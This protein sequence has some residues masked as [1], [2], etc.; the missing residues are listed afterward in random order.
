MNGPALKVILMSAT[1]DSERLSSYFSD[2][3]ILIAK[4]RTYPVNT[5]YLEDIY[6]HIEYRLTSQSAAALQG[7]LKTSKK[8]LRNQVGSGRRRQDLVWSG[9]GDDAILEDSLV[10]P[11][12]NE[13]LYKDYN[14]MTRNNLALVNE[15][16]IDYE[17]LEDLVI[18]I[19]EEGE[20]GAMLIFLPGLAEI[21]LLLDRLTASQK[22]KDLATEW[23]LALHSS[24]APDDQRKVFRIPPQGVRKIVL[25]TNIAE[26]SVTIPDVVHVIDCGKHKENRFDPHRGMSR[27]LEVWISQANARQRKGRAGRVQP[28]NHFCLYTKYRLE[29]LMHPFQLPEM[30][31]VPLVELC[32]QIKLLSINNMAAFLQ[33]ALDPPKLESVETALATLREVGAVNEQ[34]ELT[35]LGYHLAALPVDVRIGKMML[36]GALFGC[37]SPV[38]TIAA[39]LS[40]KSP[41]LVPQEQKNAAERAKKAFSDNAEKIHFEDDAPQ[42]SDHLAMVAAYNGWRQI[43]TKKGAGAARGH[44]QENF[45]SMPTLKMIR[46]MRNQFA[47]LLL[48]MGFIKFSQAIDSKAALTDFADNLTQ[49]FNFHA[50]QPAVIKAALC[51]G[52]YPN[53]AAMDEKSVVEG[54]ASAGSRRAGLS[55]LQK[56]R[57]SDGRREVFIHP[58]SV[59]ADVL[60][61]WHPFLVFHEKVETSR[62]FLRDTS[63]ISPYAILLFGGAISIQHQTGHVTVDGWLEMKAAAQTA[64]LFKE[65]RIA[66]DSVLRE[67]IEKPQE[68]MSSRSTEVIRFIIELILD[69]T[70]IAV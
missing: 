18:H 67:S 1:M 13:S 40:H 20:S 19:A 52:L 36:Y 55:S 63:V 62:V 53:V 9:F 24:I 32:L 3:P 7:G 5:I 34:E 22:F 25:A 59:N 60:E 57:W 6:E 31:R 8:H 2:C 30:L 43:V 12:Y 41:F 54:H 46:D 50:Q 69:E 33:K 17:L 58:S 11:L 23:L 49:P 4:G 27:M 56:P 14:A 37:L 70:K 45:L 51:A 35:A 48:D 38:L 66:L 10:N 65:L 39:C 64:V 26:T 15:D 44:C 21:Q 61:F 16:V 68:N 42:Q 28:G 47:M 29:N